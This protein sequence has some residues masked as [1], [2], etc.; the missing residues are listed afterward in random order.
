MTLPP[1]PNPDHHPDLHRDRG[2]PSQVN[3]DGLRFV[4]PSKSLR[5]VAMLEQQ[6]TAARAS[7]PQ[8]VAGVEADPDD[9]PPP[10][11]DDPNETEV[12]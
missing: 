12:D 8:P 3:P 2:H 9:D 7:Q 11:E 4:P 5:A 6:A 1:P 10:L